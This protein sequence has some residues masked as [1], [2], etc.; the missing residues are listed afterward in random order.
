MQVTTDQIEAAGARFYRAWSDS[1]G[2][3]NTHQAFVDA[4]RAGVR[5]AAAG[6]LPRRSGLTAKQRELLVFIE[7]Y[8]KQH[9]FAP[10]FV[11]MAAALGV[12]SK[13]GVHRLV[14]ALVERGA[15]TRLEYRARAIELIGA[16]ISPQ[17]A[18]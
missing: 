11:E 17:V 3:L 7:G 8:V 13:S 9:G 10:T 15:I 6:E 2:T 4:V 12:N 16:P 1:N 5:L 18:A 14:T